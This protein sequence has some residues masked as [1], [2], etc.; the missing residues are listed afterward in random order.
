MS[1]GITMQNYDNHVNMNSTKY[2][3][4]INVMHVFET[5]R[6]MN[7]YH[8]KILVIYDQ[9]LPATATTN[10]WRPQRRVYMFTMTL[11]G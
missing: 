9:I 10:L 6:I 11:K 5:M 4:D 2:R 3:N 7:G 8:G 1:R